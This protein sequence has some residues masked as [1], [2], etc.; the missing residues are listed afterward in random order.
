MNPVLQCRIETKTKT[1]T[2]YFDEEKQKNEK[3]KTIYEYVL[4]D[5]ICM[6]NRI[7]WGGCV[8]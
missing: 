2:V 7:P 3:T 6:I 4:V 5:I 8:G 1:E